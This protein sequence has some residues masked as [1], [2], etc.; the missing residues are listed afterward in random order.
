MVL[1]ENKKQTLDTCTT[2]ANIGILVSSKDGVRLTVA[3][4]SVELK[5]G[6]PMGLDFCLEASFLDWC[7]RFADV[8]G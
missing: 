7:C 8:F 3:G 4:E 6:E 1:K 5:A 2:N